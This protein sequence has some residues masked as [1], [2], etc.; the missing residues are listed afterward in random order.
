MHTVWEPPLEVFFLAR[1]I[2]F[3]NFAP[4]THEIHF[5]LEALQDQPSS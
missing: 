3:A 5:L 1:E 4:N 2:N